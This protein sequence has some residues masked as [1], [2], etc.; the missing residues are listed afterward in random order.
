MASR[1][2]YGSALLPAVPSCFFQSPAPVK[3]R[4]APDPRLVGTAHLGFYRVDPAEVPLFCD[5][6]QE[7]A[8]RDVF[9]RVSGYASRK[10]QYSRDLQAGGQHSLPA[11]CSPGTQ[12]TSE[13]YLSVPAPSRCTHSPRSV[14]YRG[15]RSG[16]RARIARRGHPVWSGHPWNSHPLFIRQLDNGCRIA[17]GLTWHRLVR[18]CREEIILAEIVA[19]SFPRI[20]GVSF[21]CVSVIFKKC[22]CCFFL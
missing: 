4:L 12:Q 9:P 17:P 22:F 1:W 2:P 6:A 14:Q 3:V 5:T 21:I 11:C 10:R 18:G 8:D 16:S 19:N 15:R 7:W 13:E 20:S